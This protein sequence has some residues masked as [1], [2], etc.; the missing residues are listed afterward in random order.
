[1]Q[2]K[3]YKQNYYVVNDENYLIALYRGKDA[4]GKLQSSYIVLN[5]YDSVHKKQEKEEL[6]PSTIEK[7]GVI[8]QLYK[9]LKN[10]KIIILQNTID[11]NVFELSQKELFSRVYRIAILE[12]D[13]RINLSHIVVANAKNKDN[14]DECVYEGI[15]KYKRLSNSGLYCLVEGID[16]TISPTGEIIKK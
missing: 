1:M 4:K 16:F 2:E 6:Y 7:K 14:K 12:S 9:V 10:G 15:D 11:E 8:L 13:G 3:D 5:L